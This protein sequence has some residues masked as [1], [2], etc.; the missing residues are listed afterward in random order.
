MSGGVRAK[1]SDLGLTREGGELLAPWRYF[2]RVRS[3]NIKSALIV[4]F[5][6]G[7]EF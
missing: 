1:N 6:N 7:K 3:R 4:R 2:K 5:R